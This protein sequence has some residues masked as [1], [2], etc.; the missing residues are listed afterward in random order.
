VNSH[1][2]DGRAHRT[3]KLLFA[4][5][6]L[7]EVRGIALQT[8]HG[9]GFAPANGAPYFVSEELEK[10]PEPHEDM[11]AAEYLVAR[12]NHVTTKFEKGPAH[13]CDDGEHASKNRCLTVENRNC[14]WVRLHS[15]DPRPLVPKEKAYCMPCE[16]DGVDLPCWNSG[17]WL[18][19]SQVVECEMSCLHQKRVMQPQYS[20]TDFTGV[21]SQT[22]CFS[23]GDQTNS[24]C[25]FIT[26][27]DQS[28]ATKSSCAPCELAGI[29]NIDCPA[30][31]G[32]GPE[33][34]STVAA[35]ASQCEAPRPDSGVTLAP[36]VA[37]PGLSRVASSPEEMVSAPVSPPLPPAEGETALATRAQVA[38]RMTT[39]TPYGHLRWQ[40]EMVFEKGSAHALV[41]IASFE[42]GEVGAVELAD[43][44][45]LVV[46]WQCRCCCCGC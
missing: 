11:M 29:G 5:G 7:H 16:M 24:R 43:V 1:P 22:S 13:A 38:D 32:K 17:A 14:M 36:A 33:D 4:L 3:M 27:K 8:S 35:C 23:R 28:G 10:L 44:V 40:W 42:A 41:A 37:N 30:M 9:Q 45:T 39:T 2:D 26:Y 15:H 12:T 19:G 21:D 18:G 31:G 46:Q 34:N 20:C 25:M 6:F